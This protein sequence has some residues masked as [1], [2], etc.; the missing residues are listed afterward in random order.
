MI[1]STIGW[2]LR[3]TEWFTLNIV[4]ETG[5]F[6]GLAFCFS[7]AG[8]SLIIFLTF[9]IKNTNIINISSEIF[10]GFILFIISILHQT[11][12]FLLKYHFK[13]LLAKRV[14][15]S[16]YFPNWFEIVKVKNINPEK[17]KPRSI[18]GLAIGV[19]IWVGKLLFTNDRI[20]RHQ[21]LDIWVEDFLTPAVLKLSDN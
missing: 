20:H 14:C 8:T 16:P 9:I 15:Q 13:S 1:I 19:V 18:H 2:E 11:F 3:M 6:A 10:I 4:F 21:L 5:T 17:V 7:S 12:Q